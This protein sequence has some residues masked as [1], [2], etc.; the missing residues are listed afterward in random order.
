[1]K[2][3]KTMTFRAHSTIF[4]EGDGPGPAY[5]VMH[6]SVGVYV[7][8]RK[9]AHKIATIGRNGV[10]GEMSLLDGS[11]RSATVMALE[12]TQCVVI[13]KEHFAELMNGMNP[14]AK[15]MFEVVC[16]RLR[17]ANQKLAVSTKG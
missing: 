12:D 8:G 5:V 4:S 7:G 11:A 16:S 1:M 13:D 15:A 17:Q 9:E 2:K 3:H 14:I 10:F 6:G